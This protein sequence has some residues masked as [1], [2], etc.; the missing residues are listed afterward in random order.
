[1][2]RVLNSHTF[3]KAEQIFESHE[4]WNA[5][6]DRD[7]REIFDDALSQIAKRE[8]VVIFSLNYTVGQQKNV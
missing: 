8:K 7:R 3:R 2:I 5:V 4:I 1:M 6:N